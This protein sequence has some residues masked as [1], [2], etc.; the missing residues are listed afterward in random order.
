[1]KSRGKF[2]S[3]LVSALRVVGLMLSFALPVAACGLWNDFTGGAEVP[4][5]T[6]HVTGFYDDRSLDVAITVER[7]CTW[8]LRYKI[9]VQLPS[10]AEQSLAVMAPPG[11]LQPEVRDANGDGIRNDLVLTPAMTAWP[12]TVLVNDGHDH[13]VVSDQGAAGSLTS[14]EDVRW[15]TADIHHAAVLTSCASRTGGLMEGGGLFLP[16]LKGCRLIHFTQAVPGR[17]GHRPSSE[18][19]PPSLAT[20]S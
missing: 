9:Q 11:G 1:M 15:S 19:A 16:Q 18:R 20:K 10:G 5:V 6:H 12:P 8:Y 14:H 2:A 3:A 4:R 7:V 13:F 17:L